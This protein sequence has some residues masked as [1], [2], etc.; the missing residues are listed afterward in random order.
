MWD[1]LFA[2][3]FHGHIGPP[4]PPCKTRA[5]GAN[6]PGGWPPHANA[7]LRHGMV[8]AVLGWHAFCRAYSIPS[9]G[10]VYDMP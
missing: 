7:A 8:L 10:T 4:L 2:L 1:G 6:A 5:M 3:V 9:Y